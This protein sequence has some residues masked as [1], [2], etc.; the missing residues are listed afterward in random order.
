[1]KVG[2]RGGGIWTSNP[3]DGLNSE[4]KLG[5]QTLEKPKALAIPFRATYSDEHKLRT[6]GKIREAITH[7]LGGATPSVLAPEQA[8]N[9]PST[10]RTYRSPWCYLVTNLS[11]DDID[12]L[13]A[14][15]F[16]SNPFLG[17]QI[18]PFDPPH[19]NY[20][21]SLRGLSWN[22]NND[23]GKVAD[24]IRHTLESNVSAKRFIEEFLVD[25]NDCIPRDITLQGMGLIWIL[26]SV[27]AYLCT[28]GEGDPESTETL[29]RWYIT[30]PS[31]NPAHITTWTNYLKTI[32]VYR[33]ENG[34]GKPFHIERC[35]GC[36]STN[37][38]TP[39]CPFPK[40]FPLLETTNP[41]R[42]QAPSRGRGKSPRDRGRSGRGGRGRGN[43]FRNNTPA[44]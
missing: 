27:R 20:I 37:H 18:L 25:K 14:M 10:E 35:N 2:L 9:L 44:I 33:V 15:P 4:M 8:P 39:D 5:W 12:Q 31:T 19:T 30:T 16:I 32:A 28:L 22:R 26:N 24:L 17:L 23:S 3:L 38:P 42:S 11:I 13:I 36:K 29:W 1:M 7:A 40:R 43:S 34:W 21:A 41:I 6:A